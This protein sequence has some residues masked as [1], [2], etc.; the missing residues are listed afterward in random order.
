MPIV[1][2][3][4]RGSGSVKKSPEAV[5]TRSPSPAAAIARCAIGSTTGRSHDVQRRC[6]WRAATVRES[7]AFAPPTSQSVL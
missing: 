4:A 6:G 2:T 5:F 1:I 7:S 3:S